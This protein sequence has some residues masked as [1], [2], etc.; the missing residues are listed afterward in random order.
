[1]IANFLKIS[2][3]LRTKVL[4]QINFLNCFHLVEKVDIYVG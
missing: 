1:M 4:Y 2:K 3:N